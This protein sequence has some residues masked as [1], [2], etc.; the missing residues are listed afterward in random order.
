MP[1]RT[2][3]ERLEGRAEPQILACRALAAYEIEPGKT[4]RVQVTGPLHFR[5]HSEAERPAVEEA[6]VLSWNCTT[7]WV[8]VG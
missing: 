6:P 3:P 8:G 1:L 7:W 5:F 4:R 2:R